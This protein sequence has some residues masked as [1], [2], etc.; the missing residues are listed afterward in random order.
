MSH[1]K[2]YTTYVSQLFRN[3]F[4][5]KSKTSVNLIISVNLIMFRPRRPRLSSE[6]IEFLI[7]EETL[8]RWSGIPLKDRV[9]LFNQVYPDTEVTASIIWHLYRKHQ[10]RKK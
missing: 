5:Q 3:R 6:Q 7:S 1:T 2:R 8:L 4:L 9:V 10:I